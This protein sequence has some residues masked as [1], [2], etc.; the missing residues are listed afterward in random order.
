ML[1]TAQKPLP[2]D[3]E[4]IVKRLAELVQGLPERQ[5]QAVLGDELERLPKQQ[6][7]GLRKL[8]VDNLFDEKNPI[9]RYF[10]EFEQGLNAIKRQDD[11]YG[12]ELPLEMLVTRLLAEVAENGRRNLTEDQEDLIDDGHKKDL[13]DILS[14][15]R[16]IDGG[17][18]VSM[19]EL[20]SILSRVAEANDAVDYDADP[21]NPETQRRRGLTSA[22]SQHMAPSAKLNGPAGPVGL[23]S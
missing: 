11:R 21:T 9:V 23:N 8:R 6:R 22:A 12:Q 5:A 17:K 3:L 2:D 4:K 10:Q 15:V 1:P 20:N 14:M 7:D 18:P 13:R 19:K 16:I